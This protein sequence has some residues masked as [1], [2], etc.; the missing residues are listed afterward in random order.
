MAFRPRSEPFTPVGSADRSLRRPDLAQGGVSMTSPPARRMTLR[1]LLTHSEKSVRDLIEHTQ[2]GVLATI[3]DFRDL[4]RPVRR[5]SHYPTMLATMNALN[6]LLLVH[7]E[8]Q[9]KTDYIQ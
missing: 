5:K 3:L 1:Q 2:S 7:R 9:T 6:R 8:L 4:T